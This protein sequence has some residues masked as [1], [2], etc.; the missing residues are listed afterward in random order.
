MGSIFFK[1]TDKILPFIIFLVAICVHPPGE[2][3]KSSNVFLFK[4]NLNFLSISINLKAD[5]DL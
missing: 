5:L 1:S 3:P 4:N 2:E